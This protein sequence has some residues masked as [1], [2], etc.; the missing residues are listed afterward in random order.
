MAEGVLGTMQPPG[1]ADQNVRMV[2]LNP[3]QT[4]QIT[5]GVTELLQSNAAP[6]FPGE[7]L[8]NWQLRVLPNNQL[9]VEIF[10]RRGG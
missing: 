3:Q 2:A 8:V 6:M 9:G 10:L 5:K 4:Q 1:T 7:T